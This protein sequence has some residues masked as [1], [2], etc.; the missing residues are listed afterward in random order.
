MAFI[1]IVDTNPDV[2]IPLQIILPF[3]PHTTLSLEQNIELND[4]N[5]FRLSKTWN[6]FLENDQ[7]I[8]KLPNQ[9]FDRL[10]VTFL[11]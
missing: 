3:M 6:E 10:A 9:Q 4:L 7:D 8:S 1:V 2:K 5:N 11:V